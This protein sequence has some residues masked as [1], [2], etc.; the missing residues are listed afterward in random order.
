MPFRNTELYKA[1]G[2]VTRTFS[3]NDVIMNEALINPHFALAPQTV[4]FK[5]GGNVFSFLRSQ[6]LGGT[7]Y[8]V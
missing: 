2:R 3:Q 6:T 4:D 8:E 7:L 5:I 1:T